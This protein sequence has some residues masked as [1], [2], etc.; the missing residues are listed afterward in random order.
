MRTLFSS[1][2]AE[3]LGTPDQDVHTVGGDEANCQQTERAHLGEGEAKGQGKR[4]E[5]GFVKNVVGRD[6]VVQISFRTQRTF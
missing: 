6:V 4:E 2:V 1:P 5:N 3:A